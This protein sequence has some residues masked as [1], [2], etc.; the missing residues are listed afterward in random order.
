[1][2]ERLKDFCNCSELSVTE[3]EIGGSAELS[4]S[5]NHVDMVSAV[6]S[7]LTTQLDSAPTLKHWAGLLSNVPPGQGVT[8]CPRIR[9]TLNQ[10]CGS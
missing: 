3:M 4:I 1:M 6:P 5:P 8:I 2:P 7:G 10:D 9:E